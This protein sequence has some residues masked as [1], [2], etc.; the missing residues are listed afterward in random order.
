MLEIKGFL[1][2]KLPLPLFIRRINLHK[3]LFIRLVTDSIIKFVS[4]YHLKYKIMIRKVISTL[5]VLV[6]GILAYNFFFGNPEEKQQ[7]KEIFGKGAE[8]VGA[9]ADLLKAEYQKFKDGKYD[10]ALDKIGNLLSNLKEKGGEVVGEIDDWQQRKGEWDNK[11]NDLEELLKSGSDTIDGE[12]AKKAIEEL[13]QE[14]K[15]LEEEG[16]KLKEKAEQ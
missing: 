10:K 9:G 15:A 8:V 12:K 4:K 7:A 11:K 14:G 2:T 13:E 16:K 1:Q 3:R 5:I 6:I